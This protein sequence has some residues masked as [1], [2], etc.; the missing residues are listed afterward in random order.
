[1]EKMIHFKVLKKITPAWLW[2]CE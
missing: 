1:M 2:V